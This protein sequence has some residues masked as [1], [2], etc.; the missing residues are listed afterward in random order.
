MSKAI[1]RRPAC[2]LLATMRW[3][4]EAESNMCVGAML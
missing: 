4:S 1:Y 3:E 2:A